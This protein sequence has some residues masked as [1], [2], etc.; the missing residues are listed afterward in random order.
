MFE[1]TLKNPR[2]AIYCRVSTED[3]ANN[4]T[5]IDTQREEVLKFI[6]G[7]AING[8]VNERKHIYIDEGFS[9]TTDDRPELQRM[10]KDAKN[11]EFDLVV[12]KR[13]DRFFRK[14]S[15]ASKYLE[16]LNQCD[17][18]FRSASETFDTSNVMGKV[19][20]EIL[21]VFAGMEAGL[22][23]DRTITGKRKRAKDWFFVG[24]CIAPYWYDL[25]DRK[26]F[27]NHPEA[28][29]VRRIFNM[30]TKERKGVSEISAIL[31]AEGSPI[32][33]VWK[34]KS[35]WAI[36]TY[37]SWNFIYKILDN[38]MYYGKYYYGRRLKKKIT[39]DIWGIPK[40]RIE[41][42][43]NPESQWIGLDCPI[44]L[45]SNEQEAREIYDIASKIKGEN[46]KSGKFGD[47]LF[48]GK[49][50]CDLTGYTYIG[51]RNRHWTACYKLHQSKSKQNFDK[52]IG[53]QVLEE[54]LVEMVIEFL[55]ELIGI[56]NAKLESLLREK[57]YRDDRIQSLLDEIS[58][59][60]ERSEKIRSQIIN[61]TEFIADCDSS[62]TEDFK[63]KTKKLWQERKVLFERKIE[64]EGILK[65]MEKAKLNAETVREQFKKIKANLST[66]PYETKKDL[67]KSITE[68]IWVDADRH[69]RFELS[70][71]E[72]IKKYF[73]NGD[74]SNI[75][76][77]EVNPKKPR[78]PRG[79]SGWSSI[80][81]WS[82]IGWMDI[83]PWNIDDG[84]HKFEWWVINLLSLPLCT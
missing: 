71:S 28:E 65:S 49:I 35:G 7:D 29:V 58:K 64:I 3:Q 78:K 5:S 66:L 40:T 36:K 61:L 23:R 72:D 1:S 81:A 73:D 2:C 8:T 38:T 6:Q 45:G 76:G 56:P 26:L 18:K 69:Y 59:I 14:I 70:I 16:V 55:N 4:G 53:V 75:I 12:V 43:M 17:V 44:I 63:E 13:L 39:E 42:S 10:I 32:R 34:K 83:T 27:I 54:E 80:P 46:K 48:S 33:S 84:G 24:G 74:D 25:V 30:Y 52:K 51:S 41:Y 79:P 15:L 47:Y 20:F 22:I 62:V 50:K 11:G 21:S 31:T 37:W 82:N 68:T 60:D 67:A 19:I 77:G 9:G 57:V